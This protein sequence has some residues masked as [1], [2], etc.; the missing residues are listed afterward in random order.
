MKPDNFPFNFK[1]FIDFALNDQISWNVLEIVLD[2]HSKTLPKS[3]ELNKILLQQLKHF[4]KGSKKIQIRKDVDEFVQGG[5]YA[6]KVNETVFDKS[7][8]RHALQNPLDT[9]HFGAI[10][11]ETSEIEVDHEMTSESPDTMIEDSEKDSN[12]QINPKIKCGFCEKTFENPLT[13]KNH[14]EKAHENSNEKMEIKE[15]KNRTKP[16]IKCHLCDTLFK[17]QKG[18]KNHQVDHADDLKELKTFVRPIDFNAFENETYENEVEY[19]FPANETEQTD[20]DIDSIN[21]GMKC[22]FCYKTFL[23]SMAYSKHMEKAHGH[24]NQSKELVIKIDKKLKKLIF[25]CQTCDRLFITQAALTDHKVTHTDDEMHLKK[26][27]TVIKRFDKASNSDNK[28]I[29]HSG[30]RKDQNKKSH[31][32][33]QKENQDQTDERIFQCKM[34]SQ[35]CEESE[36]RLHVQLYHK[37][38]K[39]SFECVLCGKTY[40]EGERRIRLD[41]L[42]VHKL[43]HMKQIQRNVPSALMEHEVIHSDKNLEKIARDNLKVE[44]DNSAGNEKIDNLERQNDQSQKSDNILEEENLFQRDEKVY[45]C[46]ICSKTCEIIDLRL[47]VKLHHKIQKLSIEC[48][49]CGKTYQDGKTKIKM[50]NLKRHQERHMEQI[51]LQGP[52][53]KFKVQKL[54]SQNL[55]EK[56][57]NYQRD[58]KLYQC[59][60]CSKT[61]K[62]SELRLHVKLYHKHQ[63]LSFEC[64]L[65]GKTFEEDEKK[66]KSDNF[67]IHEARHIKQMKKK[68]SFKCNECPKTF[69]NSYKLKIHLKI[70]DKSREKSFQCKFCL[71]GFF[72]VSSLNHHTAKNICKTMK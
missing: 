16:N 55:L 44:N 26:A 63:K 57:K 33:L 17:T 21:P 54:K 64:T 58:R 34:C 13:Y 52:L 36:L 4:H 42:K 51:R 27:R 32:D 15:N 29:E 12:V 5:T 65:C 61:C 71:K 2:D 9:R 7:N 60:V 1:Y 14:M 53:L 40:D 56:I 18:L 39:L 38:Q 3:R 11:D 24:T 50:T 28:M 47:H 43:R 59:K 6:S 19:D 10:E 35:T 72:T 66:I 23:T 31:Y 69:F 62:K 30:Y 70:H 41:L 20:L 22:D 45:Q 49:V 46:Q 48:V 68:G 67:K 25:E 37:H 8:S